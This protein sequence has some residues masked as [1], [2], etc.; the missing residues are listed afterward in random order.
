MVPCEPKQKAK[1][2]RA[3]KQSR[4]DHVSLDSSNDDGNSDGSGGDLGA[5]GG[6][7]GGISGDTCDSTKVPTTPPSGDGDKDGVGARELKRKITQKWVE[8]AG[9]RQARNP[10]LLFCNFCPKHFQV[11][12]SLSSFARHLNN[13]HGVASEEQLKDV[14]KA[15]AENPTPVYRTKCSGIL[16]GPLDKYYGEYPRRSEPYRRAVTA[17]ATFLTSACLPFA[18]VEEPAFFKLLSSADSRWPHISRRTVTRRVETLAQECTVRMK[19]LL[20][21]GTRGTDYAFTTDIWSSVVGDHFITLSVHYITPNWDLRTYILGTENFNVENNFMNIANK[22]WDFRRRFA[23]GPFEVLGCEAPEGTTGDDLTN[24]NRR[25]WEM[26]DPLERPAITTDCGAN[27]AKAVED[28]MGCDWCKCICHI[29]HLAVKRGLGLDRNHR[30]AIHDSLVPV[31]ALAKHLHKSS[32]HWRDFEEVQRRVYKLSGRNT[33]ELV[34]PAPGEAER[35]SVDGD[36][37][38]VDGDEVVEG[39]LVEDDESGVQEDDCEAH[40]RVLRLIQPVET[41]WNSWFFA[42]RRIVHL[43]EA[44]IEFMEKDYMRAT[45]EEWEGGRSSILINDTDWRV[46]EDLLKILD[47]IRRLS[48]LMESDKE[49][50]ISRVLPYLLTLL[51]DKVTPPE[52]SDHRALFITNFRSKLLELIDDPELLHLWAVNTA[53]DGSMKHQVKKCAGV[54]WGHREEWPKTTDYEAYLPTQNPTHHRGSRSSAR[55]ETT[56]EKFVDVVWE[57]IVKQVRCA[58]MSSC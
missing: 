41:R 51:Y 1:R 35:A 33:T 2:S 21:E 23:L 12:T 45:D 58:S 25:C 38:S 20:R 54:I 52:R 57:E 18:I 14:E 44:V 55:I 15:H 31:G 13:V 43:K 42:I 28:G 11:N 24:W 39:F 34:A 10:D 56:P 16:G 46:Y 37:G 48:L 32:P 49:V 6:G 17:A 7:G 47:A 27:I 53:L 3:A 5:G 40:K 26:E 22:L 8:R 30:N 19:K 50:T 36:G 29:L 9:H 4:P